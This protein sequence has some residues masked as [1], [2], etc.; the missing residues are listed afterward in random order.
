VSSYNMHSTLK[1]SF[2]RSGFAGKNNLLRAS[3]VSYDE[4]IKYL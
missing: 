3:E 4:L 2:T 1:S